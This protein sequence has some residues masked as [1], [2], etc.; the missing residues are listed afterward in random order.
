MLD[1]RAAG[2]RRLEDAPLNLL[3]GLSAGPVEVLT[4]Q[5]VDQQVEFMRR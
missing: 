4:M 5:L 2:R 3:S 1:F